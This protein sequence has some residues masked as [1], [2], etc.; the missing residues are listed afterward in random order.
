MDKLKIFYLIETNEKSITDIYDIEGGIKIIAD[1]TVLTK[2]VDCENDEGYCGNFLFI[3]IKC[4]I[5]HVPELILGKKVTCEIDEE[6]CEFVFEPKGDFIYF[7]I[8][9]RPDMPWAAEFDKRYPGEGKGYP[10]PAKLLLKELVMISMQF[11]NEVLIINRELEGSKEVVSFKN[12]LAKAESN[13]KE[14]L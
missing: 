6:F 10:L 5:H 11:I 9:H 2:M 12:D 13:L 14:I 8:K 1:D 3:D 4:L 7:S